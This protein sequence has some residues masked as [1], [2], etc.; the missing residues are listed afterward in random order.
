MKTNLLSRS[1]AEPQ[2]PRLRGI[3]ILPTRT[4]GVSNNGKA[5]VRRPEKR[6]R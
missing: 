1:L 4:A 5:T 6:V 3:G 2:A